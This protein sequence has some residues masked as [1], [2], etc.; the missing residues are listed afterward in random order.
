M[1]AEADH[2]VEKAKK[3]AAD[4][5]DLSL[6]EILLHSIVEK[7]WPDSSLGCPHPGESYMQQV[8]PGY[9]ITLAAEKHFFVF[10]TDKKDRVILCQS[11]E[12]YNIYSEP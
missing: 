6:E 5:F 10:H 8:T 12:P 3:Q 4:K 9:Q 7:E 2:L 11:D 1:S